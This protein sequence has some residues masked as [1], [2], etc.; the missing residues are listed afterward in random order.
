MLLVSVDANYEFTIADVGACGNAVFK[1]SS[2]GKQFYDNKLD[3]P[4]AGTLANN[5]NPHPY[6]FIADEAFPLLPNLMRPY[7]GRNISS[8]NNEESRK[9]KKFLIIE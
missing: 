5:T 6:F 1:N 2:F 4:M 7:S 3:L 8:G 9:K